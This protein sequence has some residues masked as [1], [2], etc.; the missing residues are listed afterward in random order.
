MFW[1]SQLFIHPAMAALGAG[2]I[3]VPIIIH[4]INRLQ[5]RK[6]RFAAMEFLLQSQQRN[7]KRIL[8]E[9]L[10]LL[11]LRILMVLLLMAIFARLILDPSQLSLLERPEIHHLVVIDDSGSMRDRWGETSAY[12]EALGVVKRL[13]SELAGQEGLQTITLMTTSQ[14]DRISSSFSHRQVDVSMVSELEDKLEAMQKE[15]GYGSANWSE[16]FGAIRRTL[17]ADQVQQQ[18]VHI[19]SDYRVQEWKQSPT[20]RDDL[21]ALA[22]ENTIVNLVPAV[23]APHE[24]LAVTGLTG[25]L[26]TAAVRVPLQLTTQITN[27]GQQLAENVAVRVFVDGQPIPQA[28]TI[29]QIEPGD[30]VQ[31][32]FEVVLNTPGEHVISTQI[33]ADSLEADNTYYLT[34]NVPD[35]QRVLIA[36]GSPEFTEG[37]YVADALSADASITG[38]DVLLL[39]PDGLRDQDLS[40]FTAVYL[41][42]VPNLPPDAVALLENY[43]AQGGGIAW[44]LGNRIDAGF[45]RRLAEQTHTRIE[46]MRLVPGSDEAEQATRT[47]PASGRQ[48]SIFPLP[49]AGSPLVLPRADET[50]P[51]SDMQLTDH[52]LFAILNAGGGLLSNYVNIYRYYPLQLEAGEGLPEQVTVIG[53]LRNRSPLFVEGTFGK[54]RVFVGLTSVG[55]MEEALTERWQ[56]WPF[57]MNAPGFTVFHLELV[58]YLGARQGSRPQLTIGD[59]LAITVNAATH[60]ADVKVDPPES[61]GVSAMILQ[62]EPLPAGGT[63]GSD[64][65]A[66]E[67]PGTPASAATAGKIQGGAVRSPGELLL[68]EY[69]ETRV[70][71]VYRVIRENLARQS[72][73]EL[74]AVNV[75]AS[76]GALELTTPAEMRTQLAGLD[77]VLIQDFGQLE[78]INRSDPG[79][80]LRNLLLLLLIVILLAE[81]ALAYRLSYH[82]RGAGTKNSG[83]SG[84]EFLR[85]SGPGRKEPA[86]APLT[87]GGPV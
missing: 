14:P 37:Q 8:M 32:A 43:V 13:A 18:V 5:Y 33:P 35:K 55:P 82:T 75:P 1:F 57:D 40:Q 46:G 69:T 27:F 48:E 68:A 7:R 3:A 30:T 29:P 78:G 76:E 66:A 47:E 70:P 87:T 26:Q 41:V 65:E 31:E 21:S 38:I 84:P 83:R 64:G 71:G 59:P 11:L 34:L 62:A 42:N 4:L 73:T 50:N 44:F 36:D 2:L 80:E 16:V 17:A 22:V 15:C 60:L 24:N 54:G 23:P 9:Q 67:T 56:N 20:L 58:K 6:V 28:I 81:Q 52:P 25:D 74:I 72:E 86:R 53:E 10:L 51:G 77:Q 85:P 61:S 19:V 79:R 39:R 49:L 63:A 12:Q 45:Y